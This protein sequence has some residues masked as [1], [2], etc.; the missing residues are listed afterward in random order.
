MAQFSASWTITE[1]AD[2]AEGTFPTEQNFRDQFGQ[3]IEFLGQLHQ[4]AGASGDGAT[5]VAGN[6]LLIWLYGPA[7]GD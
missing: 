5:L 1:A 6:L 7:E 3:N 2:W 4:H